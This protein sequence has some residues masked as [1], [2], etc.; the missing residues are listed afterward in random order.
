MTRQREKVLHFLLYNLVILLITATV[1]CG[2]IMP[3]DEVENTNYSATE[4][5]SYGFAV[6]EHGTLEFRGI[7]GPVEICGVEEEGTILVWGERRVESESIADAE[8]KLQE[9][10]VK[11]EASRY[12]VSL[13]TEQP[14]PSNGRNYEV[15]Y[16]IRIPTGWQVKARHVSGVIE[17][18]SL[19]ED[20]SLD[21]TNGEMILSDLGA[22][23]SARLVNGSIYG[24]V[25]LLP[26][27]SCRLNVVSGELE[28]V[29]PQE[30]SASLSA[31]VI[32]GSVTVAGLEMREARSTPT[33]VHGV[34][35]SGDGSIELEV[36]HG[37]ITV[38][39]FGT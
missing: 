28:L 19:L 10:R 26:R 3:G 33:A 36:I 30:T 23:V 21:L 13:E 35:G 32:S 38:R 16:H 8:A 1:S 6:G 11:A 27:G 2:I 29:I 20:L 17:A 22:N 37:T 4:L 12:H 15:S 7:N 24:E 31:E 18:T 34:L 9:L 5:F 14:D 39:G 25:A